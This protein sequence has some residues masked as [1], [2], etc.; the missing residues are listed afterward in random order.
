[1]VNQDSGNYDLIF[2]FMDKMV[3]GI[4]AMKFKDDTKKQLA[5]TLKVSIESMVESARLAASSSQKQVII[6]GI[7]VQCAGASGLAKALYNAISGVNNI[8]FLNKFNKSLEVKRSDSAPAA[9]VS[10]PSMHS[11]SS[12][13]TRR[14][15]GR[16][17]PR[18]TRGGSRG[19]KIDRNSVVCYNCSE[20]GHMS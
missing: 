15:R 9:T 5:L 10:F 6:N 17:R 14:G 7:A 2:L 3:D 8:S 16:G 13:Y 18:G 4:K 11:S 12:G 1:M 19:G 20:I